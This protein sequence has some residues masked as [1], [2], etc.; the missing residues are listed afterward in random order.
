MTAKLTDSKGSIIVALSGRNM[1]YLPLSV[2]A[3]FRKFRYTFMFTIYYYESHSDLCV[4]TS[5]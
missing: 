4:N 5:K 3:E 2:R 1:Y